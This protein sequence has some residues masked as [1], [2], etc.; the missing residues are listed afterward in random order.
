MLGV[1]H[2]NYFKSLSAGCG[3]LYRNGYFTTQWNSSTTTTTGATKTTTTTTTKRMETMTTA[4]VNDDVVTITAEPN[5]I[6]QTLYP[7]RDDLEINPLEDFEKSVDAAMGD[8]LGNHNPSGRVFKPTINGMVE[9][10]SSELEYE[11]INKELEELSKLPMN[12][13][14]N[15]PTKIPQTVR[16]LMPLSEKSKDLLNHIATNRTSVSGKK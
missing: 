3:R 11:R 2:T 12:A 8:I 10:D 9:L 5:Y 4:V 13:L 16:P 15:P 1:K 6:H 14:L 7:L